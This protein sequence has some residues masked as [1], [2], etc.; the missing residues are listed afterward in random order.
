MDEQVKIALAWLRG[1]PSIALAI[2]FG[3]LLLA[4]ALLIILTI[5]NGAVLSRE[6]RSRADEARAQEMQ[7]AELRGRL[8]QIGDITALRQQE[9]ARAVNERL[10]RVSAASR[11]LRR[12]ERAAHFR[13][14]RTD[15]GNLRH[16]PGRACAQF[17]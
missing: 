3:A 12:G 8:S 4:F 13:K 17:G 5:R 10:D 16:A 1:D 9:L 11:R 2:V 14:A 6:R 15:D 7:L